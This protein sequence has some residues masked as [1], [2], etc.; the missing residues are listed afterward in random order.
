MRQHRA[1]YRIPLDRAGSLN[2]DNESAPCRI[3]DLTSEGVRLETAFPV[4]PGERLHL[5][6]ALTPGKELRC[7]IHVVAVNPPFVGARL[8]ELSA[9]DRQLLNRF[10][11]QFLDINFIGI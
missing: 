4:R 10:I 7:G 1:L 5:T 2:R 3:V 8:A 11:E 9:E 6:F